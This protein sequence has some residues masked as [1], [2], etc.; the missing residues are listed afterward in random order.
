[1][2]P[3]EGVALTCTDARICALTCNFVSRPLATFRVVFQSLAGPS[4][5]AA[6]DHP[7]PYS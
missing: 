2:S 5:D 6:E 3:H 1:M 4:R 7:A